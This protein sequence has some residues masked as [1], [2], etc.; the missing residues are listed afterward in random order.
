M[1]IAKWIRGAP[2]TTVTSTVVNPQPVHITPAD[3]KQFGFENFG[4]I[5]YANSV[6]QAL[7]FC[8]PFRE[9]LLQCADPSLPPPQKYSPVATTPPSPVHT[10]ASAARRKPERKPT[11]E[12]LPIIVPNL[13]PGPP[14]PVSPPT[15]FS[16]L[17]SLFLHISKNPLD[18]GT[19]APRAFIEKLK[20]LNVEFR[21]TNQQDAHE[22]LNFLLNKIVEEIMEGRKHKPASPSSE[23][24]SNSVGT[25]F[26]ATLPTAAPSSNSNS[27]SGI[28][29]QDA[30]LVHKLFEGVLTSETRCLTCETVSSRDESF[31]DL[32]IDIEQNSS[33]TACLRQFS[34]SEMLCQ[35]N[36]FFCDSCC[37][38]QEAEKRMKIKKLP[39]V[40]ALHLK[41]F[42]YQEDVQKY[43]KLAYR[44]A[45]PFELR[46]FNTVDDAQDPDRLYELFAIVVHI[47]NG[48]HHGH[49]VTIIR[50]HATWLIY[51]DETV[52][53]I[54]ESEISKYFG[55]SNSGS[56]YVLYYQAVDIDMGALGL[57]PP[58][59]ALS[60][61]HLAAPKRDSL[62]PPAS[63]F[64]APSLPPGLV[65]P[66]DS[67][68]VT[69][70]TMPFTPT[71]SSPVTPFLERSPIR[72]PSLLPLT[73]NVSGPDVPPHSHDPSPPSSPNHKLFA[74]LRHSPSVQAR[75]SMAASASGTPVEKR[76]SM[77]DK[78]THSR[79]S[80]AHGHE[81]T[82]PP[83]VE[84]PPLTLAPPLHASG[85]EQP[86]KARVVT[87]VR[88]TSMWSMLK[89]GASKRPGTAT[90]SPSSPRPGAVFPAP[91]VM[92]RFP[93]TASA[94]EVSNGRRPAEPLAG[95]SQTLVPSPSS[96]HKR[97][98]KPH[99]SL[100]LGN[101]SPNGTPSHTHD[102]EP[103]STG[104]TTSLYASTSAHAEMA[105]ATPILPTIPGSPP[106]TVSNKPLHNGPSPSAWAR[107]PATI[108]HQ[109]SQPQFHNRKYSL[110]DTPSSPTQPKSGE[111]STAAFPRA[112]PSESDL[113]PLP[114][115]TQTAR[116]RVS[117]DQ[118]SDTTGTSTSDGRPPSTSE[119]PEGLTSPTDNLTIP[120][121]RA[122]R[123][124]SL[125]SPILSFGR[126]E[127][128]EKPFAYDKVSER[129]AKEKEKE[130]KAKAKEREKEEKARRKLEQK[131][132]QAEDL[133]RSHTG[134][135]NLTV[136]SRF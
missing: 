125:S 94:P 120:H 92:S 26:S 71:Q 77:R 84:V 75:N 98:H 23:D 128:K 5:C 24:L 66:S 55:D 56:A 88:K 12:A 3:E 62:E 51:D 54:K 129:N 42:K 127:K 9:L 136:M 30:T 52:E 36:K 20:E 97:S 10:T 126:K 33:V 47:G 19:V 119:T 117:N 108:E 90:G 17:R 83:P 106:G 40:L 121:K 63:P 48:P 70:S 82:H 16:A 69:H 112:Q 1:A 130:A 49:Y 22:F 100:D 68:D 38:L 57:R 95:R 80:T 11:S 18:K 15:L 116:R 31:L 101:T 113:P 105:P 6:L 28:S 122:S 132:K 73:V 104:S 72:S 102:H 4:N 46:L 134:P 44:V 86:D 109:R 32:S 67:S 107:R 96:L 135:P 43:I 61:E 29:A 103:L 45:F 111:A 7:Y 81:G 25:L 65:D 89:N 99:R 8:S 2:P 118:G 110:N 74:S 131:M 124:L 39:N 85:T 21:N 53:T 58:T 133:A 13:H 91:L 34:A 50:A 37:D 35:K 79:P 27:N 76:R 60:T 123:K 78:F 64:L 93:P 87:P 59:P 41:R 115:F 14:I 114:T